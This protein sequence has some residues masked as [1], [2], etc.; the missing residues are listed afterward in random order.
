MPGA[1][2]EIAAPAPVAPGI[3]VPRLGSAFSWQRVSHTRHILVQNL[4]AN[5]PHSFAGRLNISVALPETDDTFFS[6]S[7][8]FF[9]FLFYFFTLPKAVEIL[10]SFLLI[11]GPFNVVLIA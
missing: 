5:A 9:F 4:A 1:G 3:S 8:S 6:L 7:F 11:T 2:G 10:E